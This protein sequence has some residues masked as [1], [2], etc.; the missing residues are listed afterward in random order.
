[1][2]Q[3]CYGKEVEVEGGETARIRK[4]RMWKEWFGDELEDFEAPFAIADVLFE[5]VEKPHGPG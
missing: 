3:E 1:M 5:V 2:I 4:M